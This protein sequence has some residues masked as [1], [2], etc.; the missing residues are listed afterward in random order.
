[1]KNSKHFNNTSN[2]LKHV[3]SKRGATL[4]KLQDLRQS[5]V[6]GEANS[7]KK[8]KIYRDSILNIIKKEKLEI[9]DNSDTIKYLS[10]YID[11]L[12]QCKDNSEKRL[13]KILKNIKTQI[14]NFH[15]DFPLIEVW[16]FFVKKY[17][18][19]TKYI[20]HYILFITNVK[21]RIEAL[22]TNYSNSSKP[23]YEDISKMYE[24]LAGLNTSFNSEEPDH[25]D[26][27]EIDRE[28]QNLV[29]AID[30]V[31]LSVEDMYAHIETFIKS[32]YN[33]LS[34]LVSYEGTYIQQNEELVK[35]QDEV[36]TSFDVEIIKTKTK[37][38]LDSYSQ[39]I[40]ELLEGLDLI[41]K[42]DHEERPD[43][44][45]GGE[46][47]HQVPYKTKEP[48]S[49]SDNNS[50]LSQ[51]SANGSNKNVRHGGS[52]LEELKKANSSSEGSEGVKSANAEHL[53]R[54]FS[55][56]TKMDFKSKSMNFDD[57]EPPT[58]FKLVKF[59]EVTSDIIDEVKER[60]NDNDSTSKKDLDG[61]L[62]AFEKKFTLNK[63]EKVID[64][65][66]CAV[67][68]KILLHGRLYITNQRL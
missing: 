33:S 6:S 30:L 68:K 28:T 23:S 32:L 53:E 34:A 19:M 10:K 42:T 46:G 36:L 54:N 8:L 48:Y 14:G 15:A 65:F 21:T 25:E 1:M 29:H 9:E 50:A 2:K 4:K 45:K 17:E 16:E 62:S 58:P 67:A 39:I 63:G 57:E 66:T 24:E 61:D 27:S 49:L 13:S 11:I 26:K 51:L 52:V 22:I 3:H 55:R 31:N 56:N 7:M 38:D 12:K 41:P 35:N 20:S 59:R 44:I 60:M 43:E 5:L 40:P 37:A 18:S 64:S 47:I